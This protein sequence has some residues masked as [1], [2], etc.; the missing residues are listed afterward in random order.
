MEQIYNFEGARPP[1]LNEKLLRAEQERRRQRFQVV[2]LTMAAIYVLACIGLFA[3][4]IFR[5]A[6]VAAVILIVYMAT[7]MLSGGAFAI[8]YVRK[9]DVKI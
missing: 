7:S 9:G 2:L 8:Y 3:S 5:A 6:S 1:V 4:V